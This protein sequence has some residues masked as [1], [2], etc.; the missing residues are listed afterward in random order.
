MENKDIQTLIEVIRHQQ[1]MMSE[2]KA[3]LSV[4]DYE[5]IQTENELRE[6]RRRIDEFADNY[7]LVE[8][9]NQF[10]VSSDE[11]IQ[12]LLEE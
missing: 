3:G 12:Q 8:A 2:I 7:G 1:G 4:A 10:N 5:H 9:W 11:T 6:L